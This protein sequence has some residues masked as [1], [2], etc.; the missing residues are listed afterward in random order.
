[1]RAPSEETKT[2]DKLH[3]EWCKDNG[4]PV[5]KKKIDYSRKNK[6]KQNYKLGPS[7]PF[8]V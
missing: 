7:N 2:I 6:T 4:Y 8:G 3:D 1:M 5:R